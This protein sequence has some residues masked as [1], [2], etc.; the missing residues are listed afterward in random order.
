MKRTQ[1]LRKPDTSARLTVPV[2]KERAC[3]V[4]R[5]R[6]TPTRSMQAACSIPCAIT[7][8]AKKGLKAAAEED[9]AERKADKVRKEKLKT[10]Q[11]WLADAKKAVQKFR[12]LEELAKGSPCM[13]CL[14]TQSDVVTT[15]G[16]KPGGA[17]DGGHFISK[18]ARPELALEPLNVWLQCKS[19]NAGSGK[20]ARK[21]YTVNANFRENLIEREGLALVEWLEGPHPPLH[22]SIDELKAKEAE[23][24]A[25]TRQLEAAK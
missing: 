3:K 9:K 8:G 11:E 18:G 23:F 12:R 15:D 22:A 10:R 17:W 1:F 21:G 25:R 13:S 20:Y 2:F 7:H 6:F 16:W 19:C 24:K 4:C 14:R 5:E